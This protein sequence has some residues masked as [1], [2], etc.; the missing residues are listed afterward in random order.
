VKTVG[1]EDHEELYQDG[2]AMAAHMLDGLERRKK[3]VTPGNIAYYTILHLKSGRRSYSTGHTDVMGSATQ[4][5][6]NSI[7]LSLEEEVGFDDETNS[8][9]RLEEMLTDGRDDPSMEAGRNLDWESFLDD[10]DPRYLCIVHDLGSGRT[11]LDTAK[12]CRITYSEVREIR[13]RLVEDLEKWMG[14]GA[15]ADSVHV[16]QWMGNILVDREKTACRADRRR[17]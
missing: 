13:D 17:G 8:P 3:Q 11:M 12:A 2:L 4:I 14:P 5:G 16:P 9:I 7:V 1:C 6:H 10:H 15:I